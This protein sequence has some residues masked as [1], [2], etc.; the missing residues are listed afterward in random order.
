MAVHK[1]FRL[2]G[3]EPGRVVTKKYGTLD[4]REKISLDILKDLYSSGFPYLELTK[5]GER[6]LAHLKKN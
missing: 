3:I 1:Y 4:F 2:K 5:E 6:R